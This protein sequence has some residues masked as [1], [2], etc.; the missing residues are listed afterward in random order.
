MPLRPMASC[1]LTS[2]NALAREG[3][4]ACHPDRV[5]A[6]GSGAEPGG[7]QAVAASVFGGALGRSRLGAGATGVGG[8]TAVRRG[9]V[10]SLPG[11]ADE[12]PVEGEDT[13]LQRAGAADSGL[14]VS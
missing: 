9:Q 13:R 14:P 7:I 6:V 11:P 12:C 2:G 5:A 1:G 10:K 8:G 4:R 3:G